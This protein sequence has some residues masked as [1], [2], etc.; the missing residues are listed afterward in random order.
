M[1][2]RGAL[3]LLAVLCAT[4]ARADEAG[5]AA[6]FDRIAD[7]PARLRVF[8]QAMPKGGDLHHHLGGTPYAEDY[9]TWAGEAGLCVTREGLTFVPPPCT[10]PGLE[11][12]KDI[13]RRDGALYARLIDAFSV[14]DR[15]RGVGVNDRSG[16]EDF[17]GAFANF[18]PVGMALP[19]AALAAA[20]RSAAANGV[21]Y[22][23]TMPILPAINKAAGLLQGKPWNADNLDDALR[24]MAKDLPALVDAAVA[25]T[26]A[27][28]RDAHRRL[29]CDRRAPPE[30]PCR[31][32]V[33]YQAYGFRA[34]PPAAAFGQLALGFAL[35]E[36]DPRY[37][38]VNFVA[39]ED[40]PVPVADF[41]LHMRMFRFL[42]TRYTK[43][44][45]SLHA[46]ELELG[47]VPPRV[48]SHHIRD[49]VEIAG[50]R[51][52]GHGVAIPYEADAPGLLA[53]MARDRIAVEI[54]L[55]SNDVI[56]GVKGARHPLSLYR[57]AGVPTVIS[58]DDE[59]V[60]R[61]D[62][63]NEYMRAATEQGLRY[64]ELKVIARNSLE[65]AFLP[66]AGIWRDGRV[67]TPLE[68]CRDLAA[69]A[70]T[71]L[72]AGSEKAQA[73]LLLEQQ[74]A[75]FESAIVTQRF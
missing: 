20:Q 72:A 75:A 55:S 5:A 28:E 52:I 73:Q 60:A 15:S 68:A 27:M 14:R 17:F 59:G 10:A 39:P 29:G 23:E 58:T 8:L 71:A 47:L 34:L 49:S 53:R 51:R 37:V 70:C 41:D 63:T 2:W 9:I 4:P 69:Q 36:K 32:T 19:G 42:A 43:A 74:F 16:H 46:G 45:V 6:M 54:N 44:K 13:G 48:L 3:S 30:A 61:S 31:V 33:R 24:R 11:P 62:M 66:G 18:A 35:A 25:E 57:A 65:Y 12:A 26:D 21:S 38:G 22:L 1:G 56:L 67:G 50:A 64:A 7:Q 40:W